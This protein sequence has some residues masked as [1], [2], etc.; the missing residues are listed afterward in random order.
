MTTHEDKCK[1]YFWINYL[2]SFTLMISGMDT[3]TA[4]QVAN[5]ELGCVSQTEV[6][7]SLI[8]D[9]PNEKDIT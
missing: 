2:D 4:M 1:G 9:A 5:R 7:I 3:Q 8:S 6:C